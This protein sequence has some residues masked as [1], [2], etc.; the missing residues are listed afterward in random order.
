M[1]Q[2]KS[3]LEIVH[4]LVAQGVSAAQPVPSHTGELL[5]QTEFDNLTY[6]GCVFEQAPGIFFH[7]DAINQE[8]FFR[9][10]GETMGLL[11]QTLKKFDRPRDFERFHWEADRWCDFE[12]CVPRH[13]TAAWKLY[14]ELRSWLARE[15][16]DPSLFGLVHGDFTINNLRIQDGAIAVFDFDSCCEHWYA[17]EIAAFLHYFGGQ[18]DETRRLAYCSVLDGYARTGSLTA[19]MLGQIPPFGK[20]RLLFSFLV[21]AQEWGFHELSPQQETYFAL[22]RRLFQAPPTWAAQ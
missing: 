22:R 5:H 6:F 2:L 17:Y 9:A 18:D 14:Q 8:R 13:E 10:A 15:S 19:E 11:H 7:R 16:T 12:K 4:Y 3:E 20:M 21:F 1:A